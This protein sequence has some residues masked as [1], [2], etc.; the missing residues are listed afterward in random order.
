[1]PTSDDAYSFGRDIAG[2]ASVRAAQL[3]ATY[4]DPAILKAEMDKQVEAPASKA[5]AMK[6]GALK[7]DGMPVP[8]AT[9]WADAAMRG[10][11]ERMAENEPIH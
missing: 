6:L 3:R 11:R 9:A 8:A 7:L 4:S 1:M 2:Y 5:L 10:Y